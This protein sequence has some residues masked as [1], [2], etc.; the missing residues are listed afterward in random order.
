[1]PAPTESMI[2]AVWI[3][4]ERKS[5][6]SPDETDSEVE[7]PLEEVG[8]SCPQTLECP[9]YTH[10]EM[11]RSV[12]SAHQEASHR[13]QS[14][15]QLVGSEQRLPPDGDPHL[16][17]NHQKAQQETQI[18]E[19]T[20]C[21]SHTS[22]PQTKTTDSSFKAGVPGLPPMRNGYRAGKPVHYPFPQRKAPRISQT[23]RNL[24]LY[25]PA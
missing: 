23:A 9:W 2:N 1:M 6:L 20:E 22:S 10:L 14:K 4:K 24:G 25:G 13:M 15:D 5:S 7:E 19:T 21:Q 3:N 16:W 18:P 8:R 17:G 11:Y 12:Q